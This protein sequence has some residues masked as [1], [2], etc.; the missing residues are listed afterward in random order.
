MNSVLSRYA[1]LNRC[2]ADATL[3]DA[4]ITAALFDSAIWD[5]SGDKATF[6]SRSK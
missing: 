5:M 4:G 2:A 3:A 1:G 6:V